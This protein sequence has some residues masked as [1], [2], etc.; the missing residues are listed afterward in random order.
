MGLKGLGKGGARVS[1]VHANFIVHGGD[2]TAGDVFALIELVK[3][4]VYQATSIEL[5]E[6]VKRWD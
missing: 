6:E 1:E 3:E 2:A 4:K 5:E